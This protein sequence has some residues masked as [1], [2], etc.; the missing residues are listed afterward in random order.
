M[1][2]PRGLPDYLV[3]HGS[4]PG[5]LLETKRPHGGKLSPDQERM[6]RILRD[7]YKLRICTA[8]TATELR[9]W[10]DENERGRTEARPPTKGPFPPEKKESA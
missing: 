5:F 7:G 4:K 10:L 2:I 1:S 9:I 8:Q 6:Q 3:L